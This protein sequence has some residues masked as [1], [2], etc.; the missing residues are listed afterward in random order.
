M[1]GVILRKVEFLIFGSFR[2]LIQMG[3]D[4]AEDDD[5]QQWEVL[6]LDDG[7]SVGISITCLEE[8]RLVLGM[9]WACRLISHLFLLHRVATETLMGIAHHLKGHFAPYV[10][11]I[12]PALPKMIHFHFDA[13]VKMYGSQ[14]VSSLL[15]AYLENEN[16][17]FGGAVAGL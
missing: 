14:L 7:Y 10:Q 13:G 5:G 6:D 2:R 8:K 12:V 16:V 3:E 11:H 9:D 17:S 4:D 15:E 1:V